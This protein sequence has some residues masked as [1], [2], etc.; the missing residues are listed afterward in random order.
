MKVCTENDGLYY[1]PHPSL[2]C[3]GNFRQDTT[4]AWF[5]SNTRHNAKT[6]AFNKDIRNQRLVQTNL[7]CVSQSY[8]QPVV[9]LPA[10]V[11]HCG[12]Q[13]NVEPFRQKPKLGNSMRDRGNTNSMSLVESKVLPTEWGSYSQDSERN[14]NINRSKGSAEIKKETHRKQKKYI[15]GDENLP[16]TRLSSQ[17]VCGTYLSHVFENHYDSM[18]FD[19]PNNVSQSLINGQPNAQRSV[20]KS[21]RTSA[22]LHHSMIRLSD[23]DYKARHISSKA[24]HTNLAHYPLNYL[25][26]PLGNEREES[27]VKMY[28]NKTKSQD[29]SKTPGCDCSVLYNDC[30]LND[31]CSHPVLHV[32]ELCSNTKSWLCSP[33]LTCIYGRH[34]IAASS[35]IISESE[36]SVGDCHK[37]S[38]VIASDRKI[39]EMTGTLT[40]SQKDIKGLHHPCALRR[41]CA[42]ILCYIPTKSIDL[43]D[44]VIE[45]ETNWRMPVEG[46]KSGTEDMFS[47][48]VENEKMLSEKS[49]N[50]SLKDRV[51]PRYPGIISNIYTKHHRTMNDLRKQESGQS[52]VYGGLSLAPCENNSTSGDFCSKEEGEEILDL[53][54]I[55]DENG[56]VE[57]N[58]NSDYS[59]NSTPWQGEGNNDGENFNMTVA[60]NTTS[61]SWEHEPILMVS[62]K[63]NVATKQLLQTFPSMDSQM[64]Q[65]R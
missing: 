32:P 12:Q 52:P 9:P 58:P 18:S 46:K 28:P 14:I 41:T 6:M 36:V 8:G 3:S 27:S 54:T 42:G 2:V 5:E 56:A 47:N 17:D 15:H 44:S 13:S 11:S 63:C 31:K 20:L 34:E 23:S 64:L 40:F 35:M 65:V 21:S 51:K 39:Q 62:L 7:T 60:D 37:T 16:P 26:F 48:D 29:I 10:T 30:L 22:S 38:H 25:H 33:G 1:G 55:A 4:Q 19:S 50:S 49:M 24:A 61:F 53:E 45:M 59:E 57:M 43:S